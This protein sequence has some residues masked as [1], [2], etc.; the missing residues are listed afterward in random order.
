MAKTVM[1]KTVMAKIVRT[2]TVSSAESAKS[3]SFLGKL[4]PRQ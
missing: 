4:F 3:L 1:A 2:K